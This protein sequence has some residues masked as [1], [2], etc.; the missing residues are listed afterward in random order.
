MDQVVLKQ[1]EL[2]SITRM[3]NFM[4][5]RNIAGPSNK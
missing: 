4:E 1:Q 2:L 5:Q 3:I